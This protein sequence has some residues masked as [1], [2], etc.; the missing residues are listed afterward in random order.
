MI[1]KPEDLL[2][3]CCSFDSR[4]K[5]TAAVRM[6]YGIP[7]LHTEGRDFL[8]RRPSSCGTGSLGLLMGLHPKRMIRY[9]KGA[10]PEMRIFRRSH[11]HQSVHRQ[12]A[13]Q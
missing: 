11:E 13:A 7:T 9:G 2:G 5:G 4:G 1:R 12:R 3:W 6:E 8:F 10:T